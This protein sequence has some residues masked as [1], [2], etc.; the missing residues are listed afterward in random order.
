MNCC[1]KFSVVLEGF[2]QHFNGEK[3]SFFCKTFPFLSALVKNTFYI[4]CCQDI[5]TIPKK[6][7]KSAINSLFPVSLADLADFLANIKEI[8]YLVKTARDWSASCGSILNSFII[9]KNKNVAIEFGKSKSLSTH[10][11]FYIFISSFIDKTDHT[12]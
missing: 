11:Q 7:S 6:F 12:H 3:K 8:I 5:D 1:P 10:H 4:I 2:I 9:F